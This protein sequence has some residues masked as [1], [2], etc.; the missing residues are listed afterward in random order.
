MLKYHRPT[1]DDLYIY[2]ILE[3]RTQQDI[4]E[5]FGVSRV[6][7]SRWVHKA[8]LKKQ[9]ELPDNLEA[10]YITKNMTQD[11]LAEYY[12]V[13]PSLIRSWIRRAG[14]RKVSYTTRGK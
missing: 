3:A 8:G 1:D 9:T 6:A 11:E 12:D 4:A 13:E 10:L 14:L 2:Y 5:M 7:V